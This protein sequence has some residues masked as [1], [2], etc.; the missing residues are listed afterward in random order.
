MRF[1]ST[2]LG[3]MFA[4]ALPVGA[5]AG[6]D[7][8][9]SQ[10]PVRGPWSNSPPA[11]STQN[12]SWR[13]PLLSRV[14]NPPPGPTAAIANGF[15]HPLRYSIGTEWAVRAAVVALQATGHMSSGQRSTASTTG[16][17]AEQAAVWSGPL[18]RPIDV[19]TGSSQTAL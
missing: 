7:P 12:Q 11:V 4:L 16:D 9:V 15:G 1:V 3:L 14:A 17:S 2:A 10:D 8:V 18:M 5:Q 6:Q 13:A 19:R